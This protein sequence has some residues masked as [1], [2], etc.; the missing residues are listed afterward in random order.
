LAALLVGLTICCLGLAAITTDR[1]AI[2]GRLMIWNDRPEPADLVV[3]LAGD[4]YGRREITGAQLVMDGYAPAALI[5]GVDHPTG[6]ESSRAIRFLQEQGFP[7]KFF[8]P[9]SHSASS[10]IEEADVV[11]RELHRRH[12]QKFLLVTSNYH[13]RRAGI[14]FRLLCCTCRFRVIAAADKQF[15]P[16]SWWLDENGTHMFR[17]E[18]PKLLA[19]PFAAVWYRVTTH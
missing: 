7:S 12:T 17:R 4:F 2:A 14:V 11:L 13:S 10:T 18:F 3:V 5:S 19:S 9:F 8:I 15:Q 1:R 16:S 6:S